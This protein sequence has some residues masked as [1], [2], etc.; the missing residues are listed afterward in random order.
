MLS[1]H[2]GPLFNRDEAVVFV[3]LS[4][5]V[6][7]Q[8]TLIQR[9]GRFEAELTCVYVKQTEGGVSYTEL[10]SKYHHWNSNLYI[11]TVFL[12]VILCSHS[13]GTVLPCHFEMQCMSVN[14]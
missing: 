8:Q 2:G 13:S 14:L 11:G 3:N 12:R 6:D 10:H 4:H 1:T 5:C 7:S 9:D